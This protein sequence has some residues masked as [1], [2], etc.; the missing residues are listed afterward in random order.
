MTA[1]ALCCEFLAK[2]FE[3]HIQISGKITKGFKQ[4]P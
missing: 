3:F 1:F 4:D 2:G